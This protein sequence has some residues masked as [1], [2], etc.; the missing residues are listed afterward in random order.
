MAAMATR[1]LFIIWL[2]LCCAAFSWPRQIASTNTGGKPI[3]TD[4]HEDELVSLLASHAALEN[5]SRRPDCFRRVGATIR[6]RCGELETDEDERVKAA[7]SMT[8]CE[9]ATAT[10]HSVPLECKSFTVDS[11]ASFG[12]IQGECVDALS[13]S[14]QFWSS[15]SGYLREVPQLCFA[16]RRW[17]DIDTAKDIYKNST[18]ESMALIRSILAREQADI[19]GKTRWDAQLSELADVAVQLKAMSNMIDVVISAA[20]PK[21]QTELATLVDV[22]KSGLADVQTSARVENSR[23]IDRVGSEFRLISQQHAH[24]LKEIAPVLQTY[25]TNN[26]DV[27]LSP[28]RTQSL[29]TLDLANSAQELWINLTFQFNTMQQKVLQLSE[30]VSGSAI[31]L[32]AS[33]KQAQVVLDAQIA[34]SLSASNLTNTLTHLTTTTR[35]SLENFN[36]SATLM[37]QSLSPRSGIG[38]ELMRLMEVVLH[39]D[40]STVA[41]LHGLPV[42]P[43]ISAVLSFLFYLLRSSFSAT[44]SFMLLFF[45]SRKFIKPAYDQEAA[46]VNS[47]HN[48]SV[49]RP[50]PYPPPTRIRLDPEI[51]SRPGIRKS[52]IP[53]RLCN[54]LSH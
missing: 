49:P 13:R 37:M 4:L 10:H 19:A 26:L 9:L 44:M 8:L 38:T 11:E 47:C 15:Y 31:I 39:I 50:Y 1:V 34:A 35:D 41:Y 29:Q 36:V 46:V 6:L 25:L 2:S 33:E 28:F 51:N 5:Y 45:S 53:D 30:R 22:F 23:I 48:A 32:E 40:P 12:Q 7:I 27:A 24:S 17:N 42:F 16:F 21:L 14:A 52:R 18:M 20:V 3:A 43:V 54:R